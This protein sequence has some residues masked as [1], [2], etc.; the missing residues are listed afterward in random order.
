MYKHFMIKR[1]IRVFANL[2]NICWKILNI[3]FI[4]FFLCIYSPLFPLSGK[5]LRVTPTTF[6][7]ATVSS[8][9]IYWSSWKSYTQTVSLLVTRLAFIIHGNIKSNFH[10]KDF[11]P[12]FPLLN[13]YT[14]LFPHITILKSIKKYRN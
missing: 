5:Y 10:T 6:L 13:F 11:V 2:S 14:N 12:R 7:L 8:G 9:Q 3:A 4:L 1:I